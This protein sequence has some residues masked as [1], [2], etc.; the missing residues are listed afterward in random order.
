MK[1]KCE[2][3]FKQIISESAENSSVRYKAYG[4][5]QLAPDN[6]EKGEDDTIESGVFDDYF[7]ETA[8]EAIQRLVDENN[9]QLTDFEFNDVNG[10]S[11]FDGSFYVINNDKDYEPIDI[12]NDKEKFEQW[13]AG[14][15]LV[16]SM[17]YQIVVQ[18]LVYSNIDED[19]IKSI[20]SLKTE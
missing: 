2:E 5:W 4:F 7:G 11:E 17:H 9:I 12:T 15:L 14:E 3:F 13:K 20:K 16:F 10:K 18:K 1:S 19:D 6:Y 8:I